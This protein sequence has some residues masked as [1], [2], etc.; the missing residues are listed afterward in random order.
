MASQPAPV[1]RQRLMLEMVGK[2]AL[3]VV[4]F[5]AVYRPLSDRLMSGMPL[6]AQGSVIELLG[7]LMAAAIIGAFELNYSRTNLG[8][9][10]QRYLAHFTKF[11]LY[12]SILLL[13]DVAVKA[14]RPS[15]DTLA[16][17]TIMA[18]TPIAVALVAY[19]FW[20]ALRALDGHRPH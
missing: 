8:D 10:L 9:G 7:F 12:S 14:M 20:D 3:I 6:G 13:M 5:L 15:S 1:S 18:A 19:D 16:E 2:H 4:V 11:T 17:I